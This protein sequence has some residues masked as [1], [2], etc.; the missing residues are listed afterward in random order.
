MSDTSYV[1]VID[2]DG[3]HP[4]MAENIFGTLAEAEAFVAT[5]FASNKRAHRIV[6]IPSR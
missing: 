2:C 3:A 5:Y 1:I 6:P 4:F